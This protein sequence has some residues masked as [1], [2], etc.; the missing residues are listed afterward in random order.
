MWFSGEVQDMEMSIR[1]PTPGF[2][3]VS[4]AVGTVSKLFTV[5][6]SQPSSVSG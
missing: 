2:P 4:F 1:D 5:Y 6:I 3:S